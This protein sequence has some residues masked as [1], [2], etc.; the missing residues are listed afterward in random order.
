MEFRSGKSQICYTLCITANTLL[1][2]K[3]LGGNVIFIDTENTFR[4]ERIF[5]IAE[6]LRSYNLVSLIFFYT[7]SYYII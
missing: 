5:Q 2:R 7:I 3:G 6:L 1:D 4:A